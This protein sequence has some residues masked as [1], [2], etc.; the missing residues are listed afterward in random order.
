[1]N[2]LKYIINYYYL[3]LNKLIIYSYKQTLNK[4]WTEI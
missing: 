4:K 1:M 3:I 2:F